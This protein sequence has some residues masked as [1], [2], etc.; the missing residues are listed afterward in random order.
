MEIKL[1][2]CPFCGGAAKVDRK[3]LYEMQINDHGEAC[4]GIECSV[5]GAGMTYFTETWSPLPYEEMA[6]AAAE[7]WNRRA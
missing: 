3:E 1:K 2:P 5:C 7:K 6:A 4:I